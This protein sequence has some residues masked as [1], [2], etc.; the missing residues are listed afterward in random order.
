MRICVANAFSLNMLDSA[1]WH[2]VS[3]T[4][5]NIENIK[6]VLTL[7]NVEIVSAVGH[8]STA[9]FISEVLGINIPANR[10]PIIL[11]DYDAVVVFQLKQRLPEGKVLTREE[12]AYIPFDVYV[13]KIWGRGSK[14]TRDHTWNVLMYS[15]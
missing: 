7:P 6:R 11:S 1:E 3:I 15:M 14:A 2:L 5:E 13:V 8:V 9:Q 10:I 12:I 4:R